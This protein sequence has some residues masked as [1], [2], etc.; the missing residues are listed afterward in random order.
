M[1]NLAF[2]PADF[3]RLSVEP[4]GCSTSWWF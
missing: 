4:G 1:R 2:S 3:E